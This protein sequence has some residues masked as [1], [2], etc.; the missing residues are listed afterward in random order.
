MKLK[1]LINALEVDIKPDIADFPIKGVADNSG[2]VSKDYL[3]VAISGFTSNGHDYIDDA[4]KRGA[5]VIVGEKDFHSLPVP[6]IKVANSRKALGIIASQFYQ[7]PSKNKIMIGITGTNGKTT[8]SFMIKHILESNGYTC[9][10]FGTIQNMINGEVLDSRNTT[11]GSLV[12]QRLLSESNDEIVIMEVSS[13][14]LS[15]FRTEGITFD[16]CLFTNLDHEHLDYHESMEDYFQTKLMLFDYLR[17][18]GHAIVNTDNDWGK[19]LVG[20]LKEKKILVHTLGQ[21]ESN[22]FQILD[23]NIKSATLVHVAEEKEIIE[24]SSPMIGVHNM[25]NTIMAYIT[26][27]LLGIKKEFIIQAIQ[28]FKGVKGRFEIISLHNRATVIVDYA[29]TADAIY[30]CLTTAK[31]YGAKR[32]IHIFGFRGDRDESKREGIIKVSTELSDQFILTV[33]DLNTVPLNEMM[34][35]LNQLNNDYGN[36]KGIVLPDR[37]EAIKWAIEN[38]EQGDWIIIT[39]KGHEQ[40][41]QSF[42]IPTH[43]DKETVLYIENREKRSSM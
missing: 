22:Q 29:H 19:K 20:K 35:I 17:E 9:S 31:K 15:Q 24:I 37:T 12:L 7:D 34:D 30:H 1:H 13:H 10:L 4:V 33:D 39:G 40:Y 23:L 27:K 25:Y 18:N 43:S 26:A 3:F 28:Q 14:G 21:S 42:R 41:K 11:P 32:I 6:Y 16:I 5:S 2:D 38:S 8:T 36:N